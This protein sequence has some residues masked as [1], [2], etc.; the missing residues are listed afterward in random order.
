[1][2]EMRINF[3]GA[4]LIIASPT[5]AA[6]G[7]GGFKTNGA[8]N[9]NLAEMYRPDDIAE[10]RQP[11]TTQVGA[12]FRL[13]TTRFDAISA[14]LELLAAQAQAIAQAKSEINAETRKLLAAQR[15]AQRILDDCAGACAAERRD[16]AAATKSL[17]S[18]DA[19]GEF[20]RRLWTILRPSQQET[21]LRV[22]TMNIDLKTV[23]KR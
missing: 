18:F 23:A 4:L 2:R 1:M 11:G 20:L 5:M 13:D 12:S 7:G 14:K 19:G 6:C 22:A 10:F 16:L 9:A 3:C 21:Y 17:Q 15:E 8:T